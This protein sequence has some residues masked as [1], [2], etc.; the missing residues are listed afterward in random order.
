MVGPLLARERTG[1]ATAP[2]PL[3]DGRLPIFRLP[4]PASG[5]YVAYYAPGCLCVVNPSLAATFEADLLAGGEGWAATLRRRAEHA[6]TWAAGREAQPFRPECLTLYLHGEC[7]LHCTYCYADPRPPAAGAR[8]A[9][10]ALEPAAVAAAAGLVAANCRAADLPFQVGFHGGGEPTLHRAQVEALLDVV[11]AAAERHGVEL[12]LYVAT[13]GAFSEEKAAWLARHFDWV[14]L[15]CDGPAGI[16]D[17]QRPDRQGRGTLHLVERTGRVL[18]EQGVKLRVRATI[19]P[20]SLGRQ[21]EVADYLCRQFS[22]LEIHFEPLYGG[23]RCPPGGLGAA[24]AEP[25]DWVDGF[26]QARAIAAA[27]GVPLHTSGTRLGELHGPHCQVLRQVLNL[28]PPEGLATACFK[29]ADA[30]AARSL[31]SVVG[32]LDGQSGRFEVDAG[33]VA[34]LRRRLG[35]LPAGCE[36]CFNRYHCARECPDHCPLDGREG[37]A[38]ADEP[39]FRCRV[40]RLLAARLLEERAAQLGAE[41]QAG[42]AGRIHGTTDL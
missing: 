22:P 36:D 26:L 21:A 38:P 25:G 6:L 39:A 20:A 11:R 9:G 37:Q 18:Q 34:T 15:S 12:R 2:L 24:V 8:R 27:H 32:A 40:Q 1:G 13:N 7:P 28:V 5:A 31:G 42:K 17:A 29:A 16:H 14:G 33:R 4:P 30:A 19:T 35:A 23:G 10:S 41:L 3:G